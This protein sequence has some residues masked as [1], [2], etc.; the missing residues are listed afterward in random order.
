[1]TTATF[2]P[3]S[4]APAV[5]ASSKRSLRTRLWDALVEAGRRRAT[6][7]IA[8]LVEL[9]G[10]EPTGVMEKDIERYLALRRLR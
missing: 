9:H 6:K 2:A 7:E 10:G 3:L 8:R 5:P 1:M 4:R